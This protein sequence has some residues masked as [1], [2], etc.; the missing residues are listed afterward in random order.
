MTFFP[1]AGK[2][3]R[4]I[5]MEKCKYPECTL[6]ADQCDVNAIDFSV[7]LSKLTSIPKLENIFKRADYLLQKR[8]EIESAAAQK[9]SEFNQN[10]ANIPT[11]DI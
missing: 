10:S 5:N 3:H 6:C 2:A 9:I 4:S 1:G 8:T 7:I 11:L